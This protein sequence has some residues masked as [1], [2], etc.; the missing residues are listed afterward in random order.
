[1][2]IHKQPDEYDMY[3]VNWKTHFVP[4]GSGAFVENP[5]FYEI[6]K[7]TDPYLMLLSM[8]PS[9]AAKKGLEEGDMIEVSSEWGS[10]TGKI[11]L[12][13]LVHPDVI[14]TPGNFGRRSTLMNPIAK[15]GPSLNRL[16]SDNEGQFDP[17]NTALAGS[18]RVKVQKI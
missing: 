1:M 9:A 12:T 18:P 13:E 4:F 2:Y 5:I 3:F 15:E 7:E 6:A 16:I 14:G 8:H 11:T 10:L 17:V